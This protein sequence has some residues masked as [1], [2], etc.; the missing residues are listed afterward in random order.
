MSLK[1]LNVVYMD[2]CNTNSKDTFTCKRYIELKI[3]KLVICQQHM[4]FID[5][6]ILLLVHTTN[7]TTSLVLL[8]LLLVHT[9]Y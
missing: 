6:L 2:A 8:I 5:V 9:Y 3:E 7:I 1:R 4:Q